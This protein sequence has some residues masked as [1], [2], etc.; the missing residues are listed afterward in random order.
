[1]KAIWENMIVIICLLFIAIGIPLI[2]YFNQAEPDESYEF[3]F[4]KWPSQTISVVNSDGGCHRHN[5]HCFRTGS[6]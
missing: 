3:K 1:M 2:V 5:H 6:S 4:E